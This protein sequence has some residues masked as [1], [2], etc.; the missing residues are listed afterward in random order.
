MTKKIDKS[1]HLYEY[2]DIPVQREGE[3]IKESKYSNWNKFEDEG[4]LK[5]YLINFF[6]PH[7]HN[8]LGVISFNCNPKVLEK[9]RK[10]LLYTHSN[11]K[12]ISDNAL[13]E[14]TTEVCNHYKEYKDQYNR[15]NPGFIK[16]LC[17]TA[18][19]HLDMR[20]CK[21]LTVINRIIFEI[22]S[23][24]F[25]DQFTIWKLQAPLRND[26]PDYVLRVIIS[27]ACVHGTGYI[28]YSFGGDGFFKLADEV[29]G[30][31]LGTR[32]AYSITNPKSKNKKDNKIILLKPLINIEDDIQCN[33]DEKPDDMSYIE[34]F[35]NNYGNFLTTD[36]TERLL[37]TRPY[38]YNRAE[39]ERNKKNKKS[40]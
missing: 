1:F 6:N 38:N 5:E 21:N 28:S 12:S 8:P 25:P 32:A 14:L 19:I 26:I 16:T 20:L 24:C 10:L 15:I 27:N 22:Q 33:L 17:F 34:W 3:F 11:N 30:R 40:Q 36:F 9:I 18:H 37:N 2:S 13:D 7:I 39:Y 23:Q 4:L 29:Y 31:V 35:R